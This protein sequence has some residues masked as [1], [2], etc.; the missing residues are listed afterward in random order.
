MVV[1]YRD[2]DGRTPFLEWF[3][4]LPNAADITSN[5]VVTPVRGSVDV[6]VSSTFDDIYWVHDGVRDRGLA[7]A[8]LAGSPLLIAYAASRAYRKKDKQ[9]K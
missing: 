8:A 4:R 9:K 2:A 7:A 3:D 1:F 5:E 6:S